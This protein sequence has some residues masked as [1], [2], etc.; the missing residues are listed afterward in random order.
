MMTS[1]MLNIRGMRMTKTA[2][3]NHL[4]RPHLH[5]SHL[6]L[7]SHLQSNLSPFRSAFWPKRCVHA[8]GRTGIRIQNVFDR[9]PPCASIADFS[10][11]WCIANASHCDRVQ[12][13]P[14]TPSD[15]S[16]SCTSGEPGPPGLAASQ[17][18]SF[19][20]P[21]GLPACQPP[22]L[23]R[24]DGLPRCMQGARQCSGRAVQDVWRVFAQVD[25]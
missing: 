4:S 12:I 2:W 25:R 7:L 1:T 5:R 21:P 18:P 10:H 3:A 19:P 22:G 11:V 16:L 6:T 20:V 17:P 13:L 14:S 24:C 23:A 15:R 9:I 8:A